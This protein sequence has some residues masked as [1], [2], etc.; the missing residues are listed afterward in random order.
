MT[1]F[2]EVVSKKGSF[3]DIRNRHAFL[4]LASV[5]EPHHQVHKEVTEI[6][7]ADEALFLSEVQLKLNTSNSSLQ[8]SSW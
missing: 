4:I 5:G 1:L 6:L 8:A 7:V 2:H 3:H